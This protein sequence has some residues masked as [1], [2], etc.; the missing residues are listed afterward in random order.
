[1]QALHWVEGAT[2]AGIETHV[3]AL[4]ACLPGAGVE[5]KV[6]SFHRGRLIEKLEAAGIEC[7]VTPRKHKLDF[8]PANAVSELLQGGM[9]LHT[10]GYLADIYGR[11]AA[12]KTGVR[13]IATVHGH[14]EPFPGLRGLKMGLYMKWDAKALAAADRIIAVSQVLKESLI[15]RG[16]PKDKIHVIANGLPDSCAG[17]SDIAGVRRES[18][19][20]E[21]ETLVGFV[22]RF[23]AVKAPLRF[24]KIALNLAEQIPGVRF[25]M[26]G[27]G[28]LMP[29]CREAA[30]SSPHANRIQFLGFRP[31]IDAVIGACD[32]IIMPSDSEGVPQVLLA[33]MRD[34]AVPVCSRVGGIPEVLHG[35]DECTADPDADDL[36][37]RALAILKSGDKQAQLAEKLKEYFREHF[38]ARIMAEKTAQ[39]YREAAAS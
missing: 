4:A 5:M 3:A 20:D 37:A 14:P 2:Y 18:L 27:D 39:L 1:M 28:P 34:G 31:D 26:A 7:V 38:A 16:L 36:T 6:A 25:I 9:I 11:R 30:E 15:A 17:E 12:K 22:G 8:S 24:V 23:D 13:H 29:Q 32:M 19:R 35:F 21:G 10:H 33:A